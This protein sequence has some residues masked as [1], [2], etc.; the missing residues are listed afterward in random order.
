[1]ITN[2]FFF[3][4]YLI[5]AGAFITRKTTPNI[6]QFKFIANQLGII[7]KFFSRFDCFSINWWIHATR[8][9]M[10]A[11][12]DHLTEKRMTQRTREETMV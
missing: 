7:E 9:H 6:K 10:E 1:M 2:N 3:I 8:S 12:A 11:N 4:I 5:D